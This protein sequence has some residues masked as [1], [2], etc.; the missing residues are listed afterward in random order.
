MG[1]CP[2]IV[3]AY[4]V[5]ACEILLNPNKNNFLQFNH[6]DTSY[7]S[8]LEHAAQLLHTFHD[9]LLMTQNFA[10]L[11]YSNNWG[12][13]TVTSVLVNIFDHPFPFIHRR[14]RNLSQQTIFIISGTNKG[15][16]E[17]EAGVGNMKY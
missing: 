2:L 7:D 15:G 8:Y 5:D 17:G 12:V 14:K 11:H 9:Q 10:H 13:Y 3:L 6:W 4:D 16:G 1:L